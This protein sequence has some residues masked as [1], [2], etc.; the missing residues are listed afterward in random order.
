MN[1]LSWRN[2]PVEVQGSMKITDRYRGIFGNTPQTN[3]KLWKIATCNR[4]DLENYTRIA[5]DDAQK[6][7]RPWHGGQHGRQLNCGDFSYLSFIHSNCM[8]PP[9]LGLM[10]RE[11]LSEPLPEVHDWGNLSPVLYNLSHLYQSPAPRHLQHSWYIT[12]FSSCPLV[13]GGWTRGLIF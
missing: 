11:I 10:G 9:A 2:K 1:G 7:P 4:L 6:S 5:T 8:L 12:F 13:G 3:Q